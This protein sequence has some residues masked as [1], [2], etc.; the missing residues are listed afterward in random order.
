MNGKTIKYLANTM[1]ASLIDYFDA[2]VKLKLSATLPQ[3]EADKMTLNAIRLEN[4]ALKGE[5]ERKENDPY[6]I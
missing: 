4:R 5:R 3:A 6:L 2:D 1:E